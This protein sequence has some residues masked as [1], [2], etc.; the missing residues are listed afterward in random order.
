MAN[1]KEFAHDA[2]E[3]AALGQRIFANYGIAYIATVRGD[4]GPRI[5]PISPVIVDGGVYLG[6]MPDS[7][8]HRDLERDARCMIHSLPGPNDAE[9][10]MTGTVRPIT[11]DHVE[12]LI[13]QAGP[14]V[15]IARDTTMYELDLERVNC[16]TYQVGIGKRPHPTRTRWVAGQDGQ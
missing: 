6:L 10:A 2:P 12:A 14:H 3:M 11:D 7:P 13:H 15:R 8:K 1:W 5:H 9:F 16:T 4:G